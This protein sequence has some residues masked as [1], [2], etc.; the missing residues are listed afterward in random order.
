MKA[1]QWCLL[2]FG[3]VSL[4]FSPSIL[5]A[6]TIRFATIE[7]CPFTCNPSKAGGKEGFMTDVVRE[8]FDG[9]GYTLEIHSLPYARAVKSVRAG[10]FDGIIVAG[11]DYAPDLVY[12]DQPT[13]VQRVAFLVNKGEPWRY[14]GVDSLTNVKVGIVK[15]FHYVDPD[16][17]AYLAEQQDNDSRVHVV[18]GESTTARGLRMLQSNRITTF[19]EGE[20]SALY[21]LNRMG[22]SDTMV[23]AGHTNEAFEDYTGFSPQNPNATRYAQIL[24]D[25]LTEMKQSG[26]LAEILKRYGITAELVVSKIKRH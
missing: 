12:P 20:Y 5:L 3:W 19:L 26:E 21:E 6:E 23:I 17:I 9:A 14:T 22:I 2:L 11:K 8:A 10:N 4:A 18:H 24:S 16:L 1:R 25:T 15:G 13:V 7:Y